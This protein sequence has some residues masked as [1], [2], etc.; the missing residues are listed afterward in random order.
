MLPIFRLWGPKWPPKIFLISYPSL[1]LSTSDFKYL[2]V[3]VSKESANNWF[4]KQQRSKRRHS[5]K[6][7]YIVYIYLKN[8]SSLS[9]LL[10][11]IDIV[12]CYRNQSEILR[13]SSV[14]HCRQGMHQFLAVQYAHAEKGLTHAKE[15]L[16]FNT[17]LSAELCVCVSG[18]V[19]STTWARSVQPSQ[20]MSMSKSAIGMKPNP[21]GGSE[22]NSWLTRPLTHMQLQ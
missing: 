18:T 16:R 21:C 5:R 9:L 3:T 11:C 17:W 14:M 6:Y 7:I 19:M 20:E 2:R 15:L 8:C 22:S 4:A 1:T 12:F 13:Y 10:L